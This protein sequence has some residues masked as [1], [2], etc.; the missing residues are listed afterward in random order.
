MGFLDALKR[1]L[2]GGTSSS[3]EGADPYGLW[4]YFRCGRCGSVVR[5]RADRRNDLNRDEEGPGTY[6]LRKDVMDNTCFQ[7]MQAELWLDASYNVVSADVT[8]GTLISRED[9]EAA[10]QRV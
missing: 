9:Y 10:G 5:V 7:L 3:S 2:G 4:F 8:G 6:L 1:I